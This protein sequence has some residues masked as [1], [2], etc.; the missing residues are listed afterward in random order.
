[1]DFQFQFKLRVRYWVSFKQCQWRIGLMRRRG[2]FCLLLLLLVQAT[3]VLV[4]N[5]TVI[6][7][8]ITYSIVSVLCDCTE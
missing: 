5:V 8:L 2:W 6:V 7:Y 1:M 4:Q 3:G